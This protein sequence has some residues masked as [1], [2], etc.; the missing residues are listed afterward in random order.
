M[1]QKSLG[2]L[3]LL[4]CLLLGSPSCGTQEIDPEKAIA[5]IV[6]ER[7]ASFRSNFTQECTDQ[8]LEAAKQ[9]ADSLILDRA[10]RM[11]LLADRPPKPLRPGELAPKILQSPL[12]LRPLFPFEIRFDTLLRD[13]LYRDS[14]RADS[15]GIG[16][17]PID[18]SF[19]DNQQYE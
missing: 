15:L 14:L 9:R 12:P 5:D 17:P 1:N 13:S 7:I 19:I 16:W 10:R 3:S 18:S 4:L 6:A 11:R 2:A 8:V